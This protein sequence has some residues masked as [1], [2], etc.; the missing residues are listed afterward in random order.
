MPPT[1]AAALPGVADVQV[2]G[3]R[4]HVTLDGDSDE[5]GARPSRER[6][7]AD[8][9]GRRRRSR[10]CRRSLEDVFIATLARAGAG[11][12]RRAASG[13]SVLKAGGRPRRRSC[14]LVA[15]SALGGAHARR[16]PS[17]A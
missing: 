16:R 14:A 8:G 2:F 11:A 1:S 9:A 10:R 15:A 6:A 5:D 7:R 17:C 4:L 13:A 12:V 3:E